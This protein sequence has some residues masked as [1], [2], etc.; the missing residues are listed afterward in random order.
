MTI[1]HFLKQYSSRRT[2]IGAIRIGKPN[3]SSSSSGKTASSQTRFQQRWWAGDTTTNR[4]MAIRCLSVN[5]IQT[6]SAI[7]TAPDPSIALETFDEED[8]DGT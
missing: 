5:T 2:S 7:R 8:D 1:R 4:S 6:L 3:G